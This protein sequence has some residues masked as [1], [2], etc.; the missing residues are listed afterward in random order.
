M[1][2]KLGGRANYCNSRG[3]YGKSGAILLCEKNRVVNA[4]SLGEKILSFMVSPCS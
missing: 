1:N 2:S 3:V 4:V